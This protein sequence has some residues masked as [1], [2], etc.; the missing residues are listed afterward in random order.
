MP[1]FPMR[2][3][4]GRG[5]AGFTLVELMV[6]VVVTALVA[7][8]AFTFFAGQQ[9]MYEAQT[10]L[11]N[12]QQEL[13][14]AMEALTRF[15]RVAGDGMVGCVRTDSDGPGPDPGPPPPVAPALPLSAAPATG[16]RA[17]LAGAGNLRIPPVWISNG[18]GGAPDTLTIAFA[19]GTFGNWKD[20][21]LGADIRAGR[22][23][24]PYSWPAAPTTLDDV[25]RANELA[26]LLDASSNP[27]RGD[28]LYNDRGC[29]LFAITGVDM[30]ANRLLHGTTS[31]WNPHSDLAGAALI[32]FDY[33]AGNA[34]AGIRHLGSLVWVRFAIRPGVGGVPPALTMERLDQE[35]APEVLAEGMADLQVAYACDNNPDDGVLAEGSIKNRDEW[36][37]NSADDAIPEN[38]GQPEA[39][40]ITLIARSLTRDGLLISSS[41]NIKPAA[42]D[43]AKGAGPDEYRYRSL[44]TTVYPRN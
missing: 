12:L 34:G 28:P 7:T 27:L 20:T 24:D 22:P 44:T 16:L 25:F 6:A 8:A 10:R 1:P 4:H 2:A 19:S 39:I 21:E 3:P 18:T 36:V 32:P 40:R 38:C 33:V 29:T 11:V 15:V 14:M 5:S 9:R 43:G 41:T 13:N 35:T 31:K 37:L 26:L 30:S 42:E 17:Y 23:T